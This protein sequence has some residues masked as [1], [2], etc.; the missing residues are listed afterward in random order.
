LESERPT[1]LLGIEEKTRGQ[2]QAVEGNVL[3]VMLAL[4]DQYLAGF[5][6]IGEFVEFKKTEENR[7]QQVWLFLTSRA[8]NSLRWAFDMLECGYYQQAAIL[9]RSAWE[10]WLCCEDSKAHSETVDALLEGGGEVR[11]SSF[12][13]MAERLRDDLKSEWQDCDIDGEKILGAYG[14]LSIL[15]HPRRFAVVTTVTESGKLRVGPSYDEDLFLMLATYVIRGMVKMLDILNILVCQKEP[16][17]TEETNRVIKKAH[18][19]QKAI[20]D[21]LKK[22]NSDAY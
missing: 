17:W 20:S 21:R 19:R 14:M 6:A 18:E 2:T 9:T 8:F 15:S 22:L 11:V 13:T 7:R 12:Q 10:D 4:I 3:A 16:N 1:D 5:K